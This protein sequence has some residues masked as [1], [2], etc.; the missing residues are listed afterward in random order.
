[1]LWTFNTCTASLSFSL[2]SLHTFLNIQLEE[3]QNV[4][5]KSKQEL[6]KLEEKKNDLEVL[7]YYLFNN[8]GYALV[9]LLLTKQCSAT[10]AYHL[11][12]SPKIMHTQEV[13]QE[14]LA[15]Q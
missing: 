7:S 14:V 6:E 8:L 2:N 1:M 9:L 4:P 5:E 15:P 3:L 13:P 11:Q 10:F 12:Y